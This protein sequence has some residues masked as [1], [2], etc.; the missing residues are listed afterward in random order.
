MRD[1]PEEGVR[2][3][4]YIAESDKY[5]HRPLHEWIVEEALDHHLAGTTVLRGMQGFGARSHLHAAHILRLSTDLPLVIEIVDAADRIEAFLDHIEPAIR[6][7]LA[8][9]EHV[10]IRLYRGGEDRPKAAD[11]P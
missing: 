1:L 10:R 8:T 3:C 7:G 4:L 9:T 2:L 5:H 6:N 11:S